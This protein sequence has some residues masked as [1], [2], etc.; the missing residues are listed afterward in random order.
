MVALI[1]FQLFLK[2]DDAWVKCFPKIYKD[3]SLVSVVRQAMLEKMHQEV[4]D[5]EDNQESKRFKE[6]FQK[7]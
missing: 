3:K 2:E 6:N 1:V 4:R 5:G 7:I